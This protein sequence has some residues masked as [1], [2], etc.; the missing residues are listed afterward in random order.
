MAATKSRDRETLLLNLVNALADQPR[1]SMGQLAS[2]VGISRATL[3]RHFPSR[4]AMMLAMSEAG[5][6]SAE[7]ALARA[8]PNE[9]NSQHAIK[10]LIE[11]LLPIAE[12][13]AYVDHQM[14]ADEAVEA[15]V[16]PLRTSLIALFQKWQE[17]GEL[18]VDLPAAWLVESMS[19]LLRSAATMIRSGRLARRD[20]AQS[21]FDLLW[22]GMSKDKTQP[23]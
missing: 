9:G 13:Y 2:I 11:E 5:I 17:S 18:R 15:R 14:R 21:V 7:Q 1:A 12:L 6:T 19:A 8:R 16:Q 4:D 23:S 20:A 22:Q 3:C 10:R